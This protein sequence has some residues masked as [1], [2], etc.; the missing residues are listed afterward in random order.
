MVGDLAKVREFASELAPAFDL[1]DC[2]RYLAEHAVVP[3]EGKRGCD[4]ACSFCPESADREG[5][6]L[7][8]VA[9]TVDEIER[10]TRQVGSNRLFFTD[11]V[12]HYPPAHAMALCREILARRLD[13]RWSAGVNPVGLS[14]ELLA[15]MKESGCVGVSLGLD[16]LTERM[17]R[18][19]RKGF[20]RGDIARSLCDLRAVGIPFSIFALFGGPGETWDSV[21]EAL[22]FLDSQ[23]QNDPVFL[24]MGLRVFK[25]TPLEASARRDGFIEPG[26]N[27]LAPTYYLSRDLEPPLLQRLEDY[28]AN[29]PRWFVLPK[30]VNMTPEEFQRATVTASSVH[31]RSSE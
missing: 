2:D 5:A 30:L 23:A 3:I 25:G 7:K 22:E 12:F 27:M 10:A 6:R 11:G 14:R 17:L 29:R 18:S 31:A 28:C 24:A 26:H 21:G 9:L 20:G 19:Y 16:A 8:P 13:L 1:I 15:L 4:L